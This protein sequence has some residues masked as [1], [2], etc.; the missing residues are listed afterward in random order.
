MI[1]FHM[2]QCCEKYLK[3][4]LIFHGKE[5]PKTHRIAVLISICSQLDPEFSVLMTWG[6]D[7]LTRYAISL[8]YGE[9]FYDPTLE[10][11]YKAIEIA[12]R[13]REFVLLRLQQCG[14]TLSI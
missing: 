3:A 13:V 11:T 6:I 14:F 8:R 7:R 10:E 2:Q 5:Y 4:F 1:C 12:G 9:E